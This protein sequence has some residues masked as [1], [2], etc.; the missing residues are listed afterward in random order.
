MRA[1]HPSRVA[2]STQGSRNEL[3]AGFAQTLIRRLRMNR[4]TV[5]ELSKMLDAGANVALLDVRPNEF[6][7][8]QGVIPGSLHA[9][10]PQIESALLQLARDTEIIT[11][12]SC[13]NEVSAAN[14]SLR[15]M[16]LGYKKT[17]PLLGGIDAWSVSGRPLEYLQKAA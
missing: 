6:R 4:I 10:S 8:K 1:P 15:L 9:D 5:S 16:K 14:A 17:R 7:L 3:R 13:P 12:C 11:Y 2:T